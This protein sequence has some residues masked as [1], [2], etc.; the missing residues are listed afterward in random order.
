L[1]EGFKEAKAFANLRQRRDKE[2]RALQFLES[3]LLSSEREMVRV[4]LDYVILGTAMII[5]DGSTAYF[6]A[7]GLELPDESIGLAVVTRLMTAIE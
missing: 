5:A 3:K 4:M 2:A 1:F 7:N 6:L